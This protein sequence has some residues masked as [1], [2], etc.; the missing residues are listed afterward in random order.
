MEYS[1][2]RDQVRAAEA[3]EHKSTTIRKRKTRSDSWQ[4]LQQCNTCGK[5]VGTFLPQKDLN[6]ETIPEWDRELE[7]RSAE[8]LKRKTA[9]AWKVEKIKQV[10]AKLKEYDEY[11]E[12]EDWRKIAD[13][14]LKRDKH[15]CQYCGDAK[16]KQVH[17]LTYNR[18]YDE[19]MF[20]LVS[21]CVKCHDKL[22]PEAEKRLRNIYDRLIVADDQSN[23][24]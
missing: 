1:E 4:I 19:A 3:C 24:S 13:K 20:D 6:L 7:E 10:E 15:T 9:A 16:A 21:V 17:H 18:L 22:H 23:P 8:S 11:I 14:V 12:S 5:R 2:L